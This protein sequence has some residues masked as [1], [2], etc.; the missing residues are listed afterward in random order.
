MVEVHSGRKLL[1][2][3]LTEEKER[4]GGALTGLP[5]MM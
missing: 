4:E 2:S 5:P 1:T 3:W